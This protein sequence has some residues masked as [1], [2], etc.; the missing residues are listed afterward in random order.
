MDLIR[1]RYPDLTLQN[2]QKLAEI[3]A[4][5]RNAVVEVNK[6]WDECGW[7][8]GCLA[9]DVVL[10]RIKA[11]AATGA[12]PWVG[13]K[14]EKG[15][16][17]LVTVDGA[18]LRIQPDIPIIRQAME[19]E[20]DALASRRPVQALLFPEM[21]PSSDEVLR[22]ETMQTTGKPVS[23]I[24]LYLFDE[25]TGA[26]LDSVVVYSAA[27]AADD[28]RRPARDANTDNVYQFPPANDQA[29]DGDA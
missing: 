23:L 22:L 10:H 6:I 5:E 28:F 27:E 16:A 1:R 12:L 25:Q 17:Y 15:K 9:C 14:N 2:L 24:T 19:R 13:F 8:L 7:G 21:P 18:P 29:E 11:L 20:R 4:L 3:V 26:T